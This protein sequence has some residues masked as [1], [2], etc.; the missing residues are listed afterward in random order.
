M[1]KDNLIDLETLDLSKTVVDKA[2]VLDVLA[3]RGSFEMLDGVLHMDATSEDG[4]LI[5]GYK[6][7]RSTDWW[8]TDHIPGRPLF[9][10][11]L[12]VESAA[13]LCTFHFVHLRPELRETFIGFGG[14][15]DVRFRR[16]VEP[17]CR[18]IIAGRVQ[19]MRKTMFVYS[20]QGFVNG[21]LVFQA[22]I[23]GVVV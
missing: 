17:D 15:D 19:R 8:A 20:T 10:G 22:G 2:G 3:Q 5:V 18:L 4:G 14:L 6:E 11:A 9:P 1:P 16:A 12:M 23:R 21:D 7:V 13:Q